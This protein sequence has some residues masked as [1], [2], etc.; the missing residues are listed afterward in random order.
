MRTLGA[1]S[2]GSIVPR[3]HRLVT[4]DGQWVQIGTPE[5]LAALG[6]VDPNFDP[7][8]FAVKNLG[9]VSLQTLRDQVVEIHLHPRNV[10]L[11]AL[12]AVQQ[13]LQTCQTHL[14]RLIYL[15]TEWRSEI[16]ASRERA[17]ARLSELCAPTFV[18]PVHRRFV[19]EPRDLSTLFGDENN[20]LR[21]LAQKWR[22]AFG[23]FDPTVIGLAIERRLL[24]RLMIIGIK[25]QTVDPVFRFI[26]D[27]FNWAD[28]RYQVNAIGERTEN[29]PD[30][31]YG[32][33]VS[34]FYKAVGRSAEPRYDLVMAAIGQP[35]VPDSQVDRIVYERLLLPWKT[36][37]G[38]VFVTMASRM[39][40]AYAGSEPASVGGDSSVP[41]NVAKSSKASSVER[42]TSTSSMSPQGEPG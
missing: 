11:P 37:S 31:D 2:R 29:Q 13:E 39:V 36:P 22:A 26:G 35:K 23:H 24:S 3:D 42:L 4:P 30:K 10:P 27:G 7:F 21:P 32:E 12:L 34:E 40:D 5:F 6:D 38:E 1:K 17:M 8:V 15:T 19:V 20:P 14:Y 41:I 33:W 25:P 18:P 16:I 9:F 28:E